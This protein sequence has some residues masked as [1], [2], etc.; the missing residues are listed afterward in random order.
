MN[1]QC[2]WV[3]SAISVQ[4]SVDQSA[5]KQYFLLKFLEGS[6]GCFSFSTLYIKYSVINLT[7]VAIYS[8]IKYHLWDLIQGEIK[9]LTTAGH[10]KEFNMQ[11][12]S[13]K[14]CNSLQQCKKDFLTFRPTF[15]KEKAILCLKH[16]QACIFT[17]RSEPRLVLC[18]PFTHLLMV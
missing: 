8:W 3:Q 7:W 14:W 12:T 17:L 5:E 11:D 9:N 15:L 18:I 4:K 10:Q 6:L 13:L 1:S 16:M 2:M